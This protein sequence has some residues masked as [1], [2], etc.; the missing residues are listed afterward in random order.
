[1]D[2]DHCDDDL[3]GS[4]L[5]TR[6]RSYRNSPKRVLT[7]QELSAPLGPPAC[8][9]CPI[10]RNMQALARIIG[11]DTMHNVDTQLLL[12]LNQLACARFPS[13]PIKLKMAR[14]SCGATLSN[15]C[16]NTQLPSDARNPFLFPT[17]TMQLITSIRNDI[18]A[19]A[20]AIPKGRRSSPQ[21]P[22]ALPES[23]RP[24]SQR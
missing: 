1:M 4:L 16:A 9:N 18:C 8:Q 3:P 7:N 13:F 5:R 22:S 23:R 21:P 14:L 10:G 15:L 11:T 19:H 17:I 6:T 2:F 24:L 12:F 20:S